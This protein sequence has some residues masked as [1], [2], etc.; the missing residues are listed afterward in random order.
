MQTFWQW[1]LTED[2][3][4]HISPNV[5]QSYERAFERWHES[6]ETGEKRP[7]RARAYGIGEAMAEKFEEKARSVSSNT[8]TPPPHLSI[9]SHHFEPFAPVDLDEGVFAGVGATERHGWP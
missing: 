8:T 7:G 1:L 3:Y 2:R 6:K 5:V 4:D 9:V